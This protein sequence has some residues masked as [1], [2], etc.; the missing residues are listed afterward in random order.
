MRILIKC[1]LAVVIVLI[2]SQIGYCFEYFELQ[3]VATS[4]IPSDMVFSI[5]TSL[6]ADQKGNIFCVSKKEN[7]IVKFDA[8]LKYVTQFGRP[9]KGPGDLRIE[10][11]SDG[12]DRL[13]IGE[14]GDVYFFDENPGRLVVFDNNGKYKKDINIQRNC[15]KYFYSIFRVMAVTSNS[16]TATSFNVSQKYERVYFQL[17]PFVIKLRYSFNEEGI[18]VSGPGYAYQ[19]IS[20]FYYGPNFKVVSDNQ[21]VV[22]SESQ[23]YGLYV[24]DKKGNKLFEIIDPSKKMRKFSDKE[25]EKIGEKFQKVKEKRP[26]VYREIL[27]QI[28]DKKNVI[29]DVKLTENRIIV[30]L[31]G[32][33]ITEQRYNADVYDLKGKVIKKG[34][35][36]EIPALIWKNYAYMVDNDTDD[37]PVIYK[38]KIKGF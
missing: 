19:G 38:Y 11:W 14:N 9:G 2:N 16:F 29:G 24:H 3:K 31:V 35:F 36:K 6:V 5:F 32:N 23:R 10:I 28:E 33:D 12:K 4:K 1:L 27:N 20:D 21:K 22:F 17:D 18:N 8:D 7:V 26:R 15:M 37:N 25:L 13:S 30:F 34:Y